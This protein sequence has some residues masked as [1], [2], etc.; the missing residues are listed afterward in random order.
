MPIKEII[1]D[2]DGTLFDFQ[3][4]WGTTTFEFLNKLSDG[5]QRCLKEL[6]DA[7]RFDLKQKTFDQNSIFIAGTSY[8]TAAALQPII[9]KKTRD[10]ILALQSLCCNTQ[11]QVPV[12]NLFNTLNEL[13]NNGYGLSV[14]TNDSEELAIKQLKEAHIFKFFSSVLGADSGFGAKPEPSQL[15][16]IKKRRNLKSSEI[17]MV[18]DSCHD[19]IAAQKAGLTAI[20]VLTGVARRE[21]L[22]VYSNII[23]DNISY[24]AEWL[25][26]SSSS[27]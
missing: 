2:K 16:E 10:N 26:N 23:F 22:A 24:L 15:L 7:L 20:G 5:N 21:D 13:Y 6:A 19:L 11:K 1:F 4:S 9:P 12:K 27:S 25:E 8:D 17:V 14:A 3:S 18:G